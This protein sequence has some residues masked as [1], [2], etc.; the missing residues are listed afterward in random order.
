MVQIRNNSGQSVD[1]GTGV[2]VA[3][4]LVAT[5]YHVID[6]SDSGTPQ[7]PIINNK[8]GQVKKVNREADLALIKVGSGGSTLTFKKYSNVK[9]GNDV[10]FFGF[11]AGLSNLT[12]HHGIVSAKGKGLIE[13]FKKV[14]LIQID[15]T[16]NF[17]NS[18][19]PAFDVKTGKLIGIVSLK[20]GPFLEGV[21]DFRDFV[22]GLPRQQEGNRIIG[23][24]DFGRFI[25]FISQGFGTLARPL[26]LVQVGIGYVVPT[27]YVQQLLY[28]YTKYLSDRKNQGNRRRRFHRSQY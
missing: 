15:G 18:G 10:L 24:V 17:G 16:A 11:P 12:V 22:Y 20:Y 19:G 14:N 13:H 27:D 1:S 3:K 23:N 5:C 9:L 26:A 25:N 21:S 6:P 2:Y 7:T 4:G 8:E 28:Q